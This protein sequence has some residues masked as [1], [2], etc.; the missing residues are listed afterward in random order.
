[1]TMSTTR[2]RPITTRSARITRANAGGG[3][4]LTLSFTTGD[5]VEVI[6]YYALPIAGGWHLSK[7]GGAGEYDVTLGT[8]PS[9][10]CLGHKHYGHVTVCRHVAALRKLTAAGR[11]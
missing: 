2:T 8:F 10:G 3:R 1:M 6:D 7:T 4:I 5:K 11:I 9:C